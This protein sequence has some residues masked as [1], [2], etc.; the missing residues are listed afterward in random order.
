MSQFP[1]FTPHGAWR[2]LSLAERSLEGLVAALQDICGSLV[3]ADCPGVEICRL[4][5]GVVVRT[6]ALTERNNISG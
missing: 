3:A 1:A 6:Q 5:S 2:R 4:G